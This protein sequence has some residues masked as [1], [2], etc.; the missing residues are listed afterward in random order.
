MHGEA[1]LSSPPKKGGGG[2]LEV[3]QGSAHPEQEW[4][5]ASQ[6]PGPHPTPG[7]ESQG[8]PKQAEDLGNGKGPR[9]LHDDWAVRGYLAGGWGHRSGCAGPGLAGGGVWALVSRLGQ[10]TWDMCAVCV[11]NKGL[12]QGLGELGRGVQVERGLPGFPPGES[13]TGVKYGPP[14]SAFSN[15]YHIPGDS[16]PELSSVEAEVVVK[17]CLLSLKTPWGLMLVLLCPCSLVVFPSSLSWAAPTC[18]SI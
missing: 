5:L 13:W 9:H 15:R 10:L 17:V 14:H 4:D 8:S 18:T 11:L 16:Y 6:R 12:R 3:Q 1:S 2:S 7:E